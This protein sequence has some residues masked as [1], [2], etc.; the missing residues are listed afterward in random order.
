MDSDRKQLSDTLKKYFAANSITA[1][2][3]EFSSA[4][5]LFAYYHHY[6]YTMIFFDIYMNGMSGLEAASIIRADDS[7]TLIVFLTT[8]S[9]H[10]PDAFSAHAYDYI[11]KPYTNERIFR[12]MDDVMKMRSLRSDD[13]TFVSD[14]KE[15]RIPFS[16]LELIRSDGHYLDISDNQGNIYRS[17]MTFSS[18]EEQLT[19]DNRFLL[20]LR[21]VIANMDYIL[22]FSANG[23]TLASGTVLPINVRNSSRLENI[24][25]NYVFS[26]VRRET[27]RRG[28][29]K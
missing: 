29:L 6:E 1:K 26:K 9:D 17:R 16:D 12:L 13:F 14:K 15:Y 4:K 22:S 7:D 27:R 11:E 25:K 2:L 5:E 18:A 20:V 8:S 3:T 24:W 10:R 28:E 19:K 21:G 23:C